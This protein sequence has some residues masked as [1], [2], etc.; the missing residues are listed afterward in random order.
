V[1]GGRDEI[2]ALIEPVAAEL[3]LEVLEVEFGG[4]ASRRVLR[5]YLDSRVE[6]RAVTLADCEAVSRRIG[7]VLDAHDAVLGRYL[8]EVSSPG[9][10]R[11]LR[12][13]A[14]FERAVGQKVRVRLREPRDGTRTV[15]GRLER[16]EGG[17][18]TITTDGGDRVEIR[19]G[20]VDRANLRFEF[21]TKKR[22][23]ARRR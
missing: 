11:P 13:P 17:T 6:G 23:G 5:I 21:E 12:K 9:V 18:L 14:H 2:L 1:D 7:D 22:P 20:E 10:D 19:L 8:L 4:S 3:E 16:F 15:L